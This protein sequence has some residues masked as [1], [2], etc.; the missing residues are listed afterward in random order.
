VD[1][2]DRIGR[3][4]DEAKATLVG[5]VEQLADDR[6][7]YEPPTEADAD[8]ATVAL[9]CASLATNLTSISTTDWC[10]DL[11]R[12]LAHLERR[13]RNLTESAVPGWYAGACRQ[14]VRFDGEGAALRCG[15]STY[16]IPGLT[17][18]TC[19]R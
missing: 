15:A 4:L 17:W 14:V 6:P 10:G 18:I 7:G 13:L 8:D 12:D 1:N 11:V 5:H 2:A 9:L 19:G 16:A 3:A